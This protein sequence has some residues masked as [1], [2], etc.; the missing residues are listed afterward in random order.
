MR[1][2]FKSQRLGA[3]VASDRQSLAVLGVVGGWWVGISI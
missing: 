1:M 2:N 3:H